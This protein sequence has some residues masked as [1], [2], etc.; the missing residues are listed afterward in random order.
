MTRATITDQQ[1]PAP[2][3]NVV[4][5]FQQHALSYLLFKCEH[6]FAGQN[7]NLDILF[8]HDAEYEQASRLLEEAGFV[9]RFGEELEKY[10]R[11]YC[12]YALETGNSA[13]AQV[14][15]GATAG[16]RT[17]IAIHLHREI[18]WHGMVI[19]D[20]KEVFER[21]KVLDTAIIVPSREDSILIHAGHVLFENFIITER[22]KKYF[23][24]IASG[25]LAYLHHQS[26]QHHW[27]KGLQ[28]VTSLPLGPV[29]FPLIVKTWFRK[30]VPEPITSLYLAKKSLHKISR[31]LSWKRRG[32][33]LALMG[34]NGCGKTTMTQKLVQEFKPLTTQLQGQKGYYFGW[35]PILPITKL[36]R[37]LQG[38]SGAYRQLNE[39]S[40]FS[41]WKEAMVGYTFLE[42]ITRYFLHVYPA[43]RKGSLVITDRY[44]HD[45]YAQHA[46]AEKSVLQRLLLSLF[47]R[48][49]VTYILQVP[50][51]TLACRDKNP[52]IY[53]R[54]VQ[55]TTTRV[56]HSQEDLQQQLRRYN[57]LQ[58]RMGA[59]G[60]S[61]ESNSEDAAQTIVEETWKKLIRR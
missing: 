7:K 14:S 53:S 26:R 30:A 52:A 28:E 49:D 16:R 13:P 2:L 20:K 38:A 57:L 21:K 12:R 18:A 10:K 58:S 5:L 59:S 19:V 61:T 42:Y 25:D 9:L 54:K 34:P 17:L 39:P 29:P 22:E 41:L 47:P 32:M 48:P 35:D 3:L 11:M 4:T 55:R 37:P 51:Q 60:I 50:L 1:M 45:Q 46:Y 23:E 31:K 36:L 27:E 56:V 40:S 33:L 8:E 44:Y 15:E 24:Q 6:I 43:L